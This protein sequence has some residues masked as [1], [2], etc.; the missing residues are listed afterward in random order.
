MLVHVD[1]KSVT[2]GRVIYVRGKRWEG[3]YNDGRD[4]CKKRDQIQYNTIF[5]CKAHLKTTKVDQSAV[6]SRIKKH[7]NKMD[8]KTIKFKTQH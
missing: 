6:Q 1:G 5:I 7:K 8:N 2:F 3:V 4:K